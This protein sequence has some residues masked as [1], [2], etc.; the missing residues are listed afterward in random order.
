MIKKP[1]RKRREI[2]YT[3]EQWEQIKAE[4]SG[5]IVP[6]LDFLWTTGCRPREARLLETRHIHGDLVI[7]P[8]DE[9]KGE[10]DSRVSFL[11][12]PAKKIL[13]PLMNQSGPLF[14][15]IRGN[16]W[17]KDAIKGR[18]TRISKKVGFRVIAYGARHSYATN[19]L[20]RSV[21]PVSL[22]HL[23]GHKDTRMINNYAHLSQNHAFLRQQTA[24]S[25]GGK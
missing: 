17:T 12:A 18:L 24:I 22:S 4:A 7:F 1:A 14:L 3:P 23:M 19:A 9:S 6:L 20:I 13:D 10:R 15:N 25:N 21:D 16:P 5:A 8:P 11:P 2:V